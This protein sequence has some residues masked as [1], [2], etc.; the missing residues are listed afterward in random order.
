VSRGR[1]LVLP[2]GAAVLFAA[3]L[4]RVSGF[5]TDDSYIHLVFARNFARGDGFAFNPGE[6]VYGFTSPL[7][8]L[9]LAAGHA[10][11]PDWLA[12]SRTLGLLFTLLAVL[13]T[14]R[15]ARAAGGSPAASLAAAASLALN[16]WF[17]RWSLSG[18]ET[19]L[20]AF[21]V[22]LGLERVLRSPSAS[23]AG[24]AILA[25]AALARP[26]ALLAFGLA[27]AWALASER[28]GSATPALAGVLAGG[29]I[30]AAWAVWVHAGT[31][32]WIPTAYT[33]KR[34]HAAATLSS[35]AHETGYLLG[36]VGITDALLVL[37]CAGTLWHFA[38]RRAAAG[39]PA[40]VPS[41][42]ALALLLL[43]PAALA[44]FFLIARVQFISRYWVPVTPALCAAAWVG[45]E[46]TFG[47]RARLG[48]GALYFGQQAAVLLFLVGPQIDAFAR[49]LH[50]GP[51][52]IGRWLH[53][54]AA[55]DAVVA[56]PDI[57][58]IGFFGERYVLDVGGLVTPA[59]AP[60]L[61]R[62]DLPEI[63]REGLYEE[64]GVPDYLVDRAPR[65]GVLADDR[66]ELLLSSRIDNL[67]LSRPKPQYYSLYRVLKPGDA[68][69]VRTA[70]GTYRPAQRARR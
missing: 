34:V 37:A 49:G 5:F 33:V 28:R 62:H 12:L 10:V 52:E 47:R 1:G 36:V 14:F 24:L 50:R 19:S 4:A 17:L 64:V 59:M 39:A 35:A 2:I 44:A 20:A 9:L 22:A 54:N 26:E 53:A 42:G 68:P 51:A 60:I 38:R 25:L 29:A 16:A 8:M 7:W 23:T 30:L 21:L 57:G 69:P 70:E 46:L 32:S 65:A 58:A 67:G 27:A 11:V 31:G 61:A 63:M 56:T 55:S 13:A 66:H 18:M 3:A 41:R 6:A 15:L 48:L 40:S 45:A 43:W